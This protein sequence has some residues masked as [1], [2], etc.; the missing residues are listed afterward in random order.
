MPVFDQ[1]YQHWSG[2]LSGHAWRWLTVARHGVRVGMKNIFLRLFIIASWLPAAFMA[3]ILCAWGLL[4]HKSPLVESLRPV[5]AF[6][7]PPE[8]IAD[9][10]HYRVHVWTLCYHY[11]L[12]FE[13]YVSM[14]V[15]LLA[16]PSLISLDLR[17]NALPLYFARPLRRADYFVGKLG[18]VAWFLGLVIIVP[19]LIAYVLGLLFSLDLS[20]VRD[21]YPVL[22]A[23][24]AYGAV[25][26]LSA[27]TLI[28][29]LSSLTRN[30]R[31]VALFWV[32]LWFVSSI[33]GT[34]LNAV[35][36][37]Q[38]RM[39]TARAQQEAYM[40]AP[41]VVRQ[42][43]TREEIMA[44][45]LAQQEARRKAQEKLVEDELEASRHNW[46][47]LLSYTGNLSRIGQQL[48]N[49]DAAKI[50]ITKLYGPADGDRL[51]LE[52]IGPQYPWYW[53]AAVLT[54][55]FGLSVCIL[56]FRVRSLDRL[57]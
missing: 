26:V 35:D 15:V 19:S 44:A 6:F 54:A 17:F 5:L 33:V 9:P 23:S 18:V 41:Q 13:L 43:Q 34:I 20:I 2:T 38:R 39:A 8:M 49:T 56:N 32:G 57:R 42:P 22:L 29:A 46:R 48:L 50:E 31:Y 1:G 27:G 47:W 3:F 40:A 52:W 12:S 16:G 11:F 25:I 21:T 36:E 24:L 10:L 7:F 45:Q 14:V 30:S 37:E 53:S 55:L 28:L 4:E 51:L